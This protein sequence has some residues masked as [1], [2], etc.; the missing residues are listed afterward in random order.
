MEHK[1]DLEDITIVPAELSN[2]KSRSEINI[3]NL[4]LIAAPMDSV[5]DKHSMLIFTHHKILTCSIRTEVLNL[6]QP[7]YTC[8]GVSLQQ[9][10]YILHSTESLKTLRK[11]QGLLID[12]A[13]GH[14]KHLF[15][16]VKLFKSMFPTV[17]LMVGNIANPETY[18]N[19]C[20]ILNE[21]DY[22]RLSIGSGSACLTGANLGVY[23][24]MG[25][26]IDECYQISATFNSAPKIVADGGFR[27]YDDIIKALNLGA[28]FVMLGGIFAK[29]L[30]ACGD[31]Y[32]KGFN[33]TNCKYT[34]FKYG[35]KL[36]RKYRGMSTKEVQRSVGKS[37]LKTSEGISFKTPVLYTLESWT[38]NF[39]DYLKSAMSYSNTLSL[40]E[41][42]GKRN[43][44]Q[45]TPNAI[46]R[47][48][49]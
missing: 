35:F 43:F 10:E 41:F 27:N 20:E 39:I 2:I 22:I 44:I 49:K 18:K 25:S 19:Y 5:I 30:D 40:K 23:Y 47:Y 29:T 45:I 3:D 14:M 6:D 46:K 11:N 38:N 42:I 17:P 16:L 36:Y 9:F 21:N 1:F 48:K 37:I 24:P 4:P 33:V 8:I 13:N 15:D 28:D 7:F 31:V 34:L 26:L 12:I 32:F